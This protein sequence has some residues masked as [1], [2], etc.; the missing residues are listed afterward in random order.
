ME[1]MAAAG[2]SRWLGRA[3]SSLGLGHMQAFARHPD[4]L[5]EASNWVALVIGT[6]LPFW[7]LY[8]WWAAGSQAM[9]SALLT[10]AWTPVF[11][12]IPLLSRRNGLAG[13]L[14][15]V[16]SGLGNTV[17]TLWV[18]G[19]NS[20]SGLFFAP[21]AALA[22]ILFRRAERWWMLALTTL[23]IIL[24]SLLQAYPPAGLHHY[25]EQAAHALFILNGFSI[26]VVIIVFGWLQGDV[27]RRMEQKA[28]LEA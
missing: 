8:V 14:A 25:D 15:M 11:L 23:T 17:F 3:A 9:P 21:C 4:P 18:L 5:V 19:G 12:V 20:G 6:H 10:L 2:Q 27:Y 22:A 28:A 16:A 1:H 13:R 7:P 24:W 26:G